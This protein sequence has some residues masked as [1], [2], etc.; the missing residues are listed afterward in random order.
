MTTWCTRS[1]PV[2]PRRTLGSFRSRARHAPSTLL[3]AANE[4]CELESRIRA[5]ERQLE[6]LAD[7]LPSR[8]RSDQQALE[9]SNLPQMCVKVDLIHVDRL[10]HTQWTRNRMPENRSAQTR[11]IRTAYVRS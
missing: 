8:V 7:S 2:S 4:V 10:F 6:S 5:V 11:V 9:P 3:S 1:S